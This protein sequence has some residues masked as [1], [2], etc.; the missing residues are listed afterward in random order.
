MSIAAAVRLDDVLDD[1][2]AEA[3]AAELA[4]ARLVD[5]VEALGQARQILRRHADAGVLD[6]ELDVARRVRRRSAVRQRR[7]STATG[8]ARTVTRPPFGVYL[9]ALSTR[10]TSACS[11]RS[12]S[13]SSGGVSGA[14]RAAQRH[15]ALRRRLARSTSKVASTTFSAPHRAAAQLGAAELEIGEGQQVV[16]Q[17]AEPFGVALDDAEEAARACRGSSS[18]PPSSV[19]V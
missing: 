14:T 8:R 6:R 15:A 7:R 9:I 5:A 2:Q 11:S 12:W 3:G 18:A 1:G 4:R 10:L 17:A 16:D 13:A 19:S